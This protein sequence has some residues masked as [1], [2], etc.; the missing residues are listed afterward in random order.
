[1]NNDRFDDIGFLTILRQLQKQNLLHDADKYLLLSLLKSEW[2]KQA[3]AAIVDGDD[4][5]LE[6]K[7]I[8]RRF[9]AS[10]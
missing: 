2:G 9:S 5:K 7:P 3:A 8:L 6:Q 4:G 10:F 1:M